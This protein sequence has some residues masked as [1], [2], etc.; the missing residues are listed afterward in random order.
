LVAVTRERRYGPSRLRADDDDDMA[1]NQGQGW[2]KK[3]EW[4][5]TYVRA[6]GG[7]ID[8]IAFLATAVVRDT[9]RAARRSPVVPPGFCN[10]GEV[11]YGQWCIA[12]NGGGY[13]QTGVAKGLKVP[14]LLMI[15][16]LSIRCKKTR[17]LVYGVYPRIPPPIHHWVLVYRGS[18]VRSPPVPVVLSV[19]QRGSTALQCICRVIRRSSMTM[20]AHTYYIIFGR[21]HIGGK[22]PSS[23]P[24]R[25]HWRG[26]SP[27]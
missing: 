9:G 11:R 21:P 4:K 20:K 17:R 14:C 1:K 5:Q 25:R 27:V 6:G 7:V 15:T 2:Y 22:L 10:R 13:T 16:E 3:I 26:L 23:S 19:Y 24:W 12:K 18:R 8:S